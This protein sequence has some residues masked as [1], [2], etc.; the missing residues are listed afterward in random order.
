MNL[1]VGKGIS[2]LCYTMSKHGFSEEELS[3][4]QEAFNMFD[5]DGDGTITVLE[6]GT[7]MRS[8]GRKT[9]EKEVKDMIKEVDTDGN[10]EIDFDEF[11]DLM[12]RKMDGRSFE[13]EL[14]EVFMTLDDDG[15]GFI[16]DDEIR[17]IMDALGEKVTDQDIREMIKFADSDGD[18]QVTLEDFMRVM[19]LGKSS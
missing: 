9:T 10:G 1:S 6:L 12:A 5:K 17:M 4:F 13:D 19:T 2:V 7:V 15:S 14:K 18:D 11:L 16:T 8:L 3:E